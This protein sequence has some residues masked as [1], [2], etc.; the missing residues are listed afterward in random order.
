MTERRPGP[1]G[2]VTSPDG[3]S[4][5]YW[6]SG[7]AA[8]SA[9]PLVIVHGTTSDHST[10][11]ELVPHAAEDRTVYV[12]DRRGRGPST[13][14]PADR[15]Y[16]LD[17]EFADAAA[18]IEEVARIEGSQV[19]VLGHSFGA[20]VAM[21]ALPR[22]GRVH[23]AVAYSPGFGGAYPDGALERVETAVASDDLDTA[24]YVIFREVIGMR[25]ED[26]DLLKQSPVWSVRKQLAWSVPRECRVDAT[27][28]EAHQ[29]DLQ[30]I[31]TRVLVLS[32]E[33]NTPEK[34]AIAAR[35]ASAVPGATLA[36]LPGQAHTAHHSAPEALLCAV[37]EFC[38]RP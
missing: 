18:V 36:E 3:T 31:D 28:L 17:L 24:L 27:F 26:I 14:G 9:R 10:Y 6:R 5:A 15:P 21:G 12:Y 33:T 8:A 25:T 20:F 30:A 38:D 1:D 35:L 37:R 7:T 4:L 16:G 34:K 23:A 29:S 13:D 11:N 32:G 19:D 22:T 2:S